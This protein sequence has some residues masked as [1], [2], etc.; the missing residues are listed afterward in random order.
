M[1]SCS[2][3]ATVGRIRWWLATVSC[4]ALAIVLASCSTGGPTKSGSARTAADIVSWRGCTEQLTLATLTGQMRACVTYSYGHGRLRV[5]AVAA[6]YK[7]T[8]GYDLP[9]FSFVFHRPS[10]A[11]VDYRY[12]SPVFEFE[13]VFSRNTGLIHLAR[14]A[15]IHAGDVL[16]VSLW[17]IEANSG[18]L[19]Q[20]ASVTLTLYPQGL[21][22]PQLGTSAGT[23]ES[24]D[25]C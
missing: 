7:T 11:V 3:G 25:Q 17:A 2:Q 19:A 20:M 13:N 1:T 22:C 10:S 24:T 21:S 15:D 16:Q 4:T 6:S 12:A 18:Q 8:N 14:T 9:Y 23:N 5:S